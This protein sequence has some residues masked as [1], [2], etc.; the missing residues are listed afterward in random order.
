MAWQDT[1]CKII[2]AEYTTNY[3]AQDDVA[4]QDA[5]EDSSVHNHDSSPPP[6]TDE[7]EDAWLDKSSDSDEVRS[8]IYHP[9]SN[10]VWRA[11][12]LVSNATLTGHLQSAHKPSHVAKR[13]Y[14]R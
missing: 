8:S 1:A 5:P 3:T 12:R 4:S 14:H 11:G 2:E 6:E 9:L 10:C 13:G 7:G